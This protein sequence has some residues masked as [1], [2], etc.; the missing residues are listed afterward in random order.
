[1]KKKAYCYK[2]NLHFLFL[3]AICPKGGKFLETWEF[4]VFFAGINF[5]GFNKSEYFAVK[6]FSRFWAKTEKINT[7][8]N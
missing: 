3:T 5:R 7:C 4:S 2:I 1:M 6:N 8:E